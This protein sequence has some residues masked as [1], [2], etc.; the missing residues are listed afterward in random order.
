MWAWGAE[1]YGLVCA[2]VRQDI[3]LL[4]AL[5]RLALRIQR[6]WELTRRNN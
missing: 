1:F 4:T 3:A 5:V 6:E 2:D